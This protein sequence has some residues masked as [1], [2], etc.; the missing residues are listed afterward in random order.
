MGRRWL[1]TF[2]TGDEGVYHYLCAVEEISELRLPDVQCVAVVDRQPI[3]EAHHSLLCNTRALR[4]Y[5][6]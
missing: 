3:L 1:F 6:G 5:E 2:S 4:E